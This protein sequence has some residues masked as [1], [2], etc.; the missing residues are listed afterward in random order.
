MIKTGAGCFKWGILIAFLVTLLVISGCNLKSDLIIN[1]VE[2]YATYKV[3]T[4]VTEIGLW[5]RLKNNNN[6]KGNIKNWSFTIKQGDEVVLV[7]NKNNFQEVLGDS[8]Y[9]F[10][11]FNITGEGSIYVDNWSRPYCRPYFGDLFDGKNPN[12]VEV[13]VDIENGDEYRLSGSYPFV[14]ERE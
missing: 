1:H 11:D 14:M 4:E 5:I 6:N 13:T 7:I 2:A 10:T 9:N 8:L 3:E 12:K